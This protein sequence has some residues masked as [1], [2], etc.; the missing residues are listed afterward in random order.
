MSDR[1]RVVGR[2]GSGGGHDRRPIWWAVALVAVAAAFLLGRLTGDGGSTSAPGRAAGAST[3]QASVP[4][5]YA[6][7][8]DGAVAAALNY[9][10]V[11][12]RDDFLVPARRRKVLDTIATPGFARRFETKAAR[13]YALALR[14][15]LGEG[16]RS[17]AS[18]VSLS[19]PL[20]YKVVSY[21]RDRAVV[22]GWGVAVSGNTAGF[23]P[24]IDFQTTRSVL[25]WTDGD[26]KLDGGESTPGPA[27]AL[28][29][30]VD[31]ST[32]TDFVDA[33]DAMQS[34]QYAP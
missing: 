24:Q 31:P 3:V 25:V 10:A 22:A 12:A 16:L 2:G 4:V 14:G 32:A 9:G 19:A 7:S 21:T 17:G 6:H 34:V 18:T 15:P 28:A 30:S 20:A 11:A 1:V 27:P 23:R 8:R 29:A 33:L 26:W 13:A 5:G